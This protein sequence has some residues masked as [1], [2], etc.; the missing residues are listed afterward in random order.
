M[1][2]IERDDFRETDSKD[3][4]G[5]APG[6]SVMLRCALVLF[7]FAA[8]EAVWTSESLKGIRTATL[9]A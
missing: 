7:D 9:G 4:Y 6:K 3:F 2:Y 1:V 8:F 5:L